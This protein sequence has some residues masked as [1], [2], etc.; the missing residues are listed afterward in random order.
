LAEKQVRL[1]TKLMEWM[2]YKWMIL[3]IQRFGL[4]R[5]AIQR[6]TFPALTIVNIDKMVW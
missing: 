2:L 3:K 1:S 5:T 4:H 6:S